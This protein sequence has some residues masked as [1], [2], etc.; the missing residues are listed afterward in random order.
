MKMIPIWVDKELE[1]ED[2]STAVD[3]ENVVKWI[4]LMSHL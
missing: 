2:F 4:F 3:L 1:N